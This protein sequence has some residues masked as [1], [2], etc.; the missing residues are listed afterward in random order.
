M[1]LWVGGLRRAWQA[2]FIAP[3]AVFVLMFI[4]A[5]CSAS[6]HTRPS[7]CC[8]LCPQTIMARP[9]SFFDASTKGDLVSRLTVDVT[10]LQTTLA[11][12]RSWA[13]R[14]TLR[15][16]GFGAAGWNATAGN[17]P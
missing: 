10:V 11:G 15:S 12:G 9:Q 16:Q 7:V 2:G 14:C 13:L 3:G 5:H 6:K 17:V 8:A 4:A 1:W